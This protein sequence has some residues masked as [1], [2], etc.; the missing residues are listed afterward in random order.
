MIKSKKIYNIAFILLCSL[1]SILQS[2]KQTET[3]EMQ[4]E[5]QFNPQ[6]MRDLAGLRLGGLLNKRDFEHALPYLDSLKQVYPNDPQF[7]FCEGW[8]YNLLGDSLRARMA[9]S[10]SLHFY[11][12]L[13]AKKPYQDYMLNRACIIQYLFGQGAYNKALDEI[14]STTNNPNDSTY[15]GMLK[16][17]NF[18]AKET[19]FL[20]LSNVVP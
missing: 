15:I 7:L 10:K 17:I 1:P 13:I 16:M 12:S 5:L 3:K 19:L 8:A 9:Y 2:C 11:D 20:N 18:K 4:E 14:L 6:Q